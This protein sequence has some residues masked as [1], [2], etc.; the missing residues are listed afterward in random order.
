MIVAILVLAMGC[1][2]D[3]KSGV[4]ND[5]QPSLPG[6][7][8]NVRVIGRSLEG[9]AIEAIFL[10]EGPY[11]ILIIASIH[12]T[13]PAGTPLLRRLAHHLREEPES[14]EGRRI[15]LVPNANPDGVFHR[16]RGNM[17][18]VALTNDPAPTR[19]TSDGL[20]NGRRRGVT[21]SIGG[22]V[23]LNRNFPS[24][25]FTPRDRHGPAP[26][27]EPESRAL[28]ELLHLH[29]PRRVISIHQPLGCID[30]DGPPEAQDLAEAMS[31]ASGQVFPSPETESTT[32]ASTSPLP[33]KKLGARPGSFGSYVG[34]DLGIPTITLELPGHATAMS[35]EELWRRYGTMMVESLK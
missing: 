15:I 14:L 17:R 16:H 2:S 29:P 27:S 9:R 25:N 26:L 22:G 18:G 1:R 35:V 33:V 8:D 31:V 3:R 32:V 34:V 24:R 30:W 28:F 19:Q 13:E 23:D 5:A 7:G 4:V 12:G 11:T 6:G 10:G 20:A 21:S